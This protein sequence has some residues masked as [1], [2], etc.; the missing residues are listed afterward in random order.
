MI[1]GDIK[2]SQF[3]SIDGM[4]KLND[5]NGC[6]FPSWDE[7]KGEYCNREHVEEQEKTDIFR[8]GQLFNYL[9]RGKRPYDDPTTVTSPINSTH[10][11]DAYVKRA[12]IMCMR[13]HHSTARQ[14]ANFLHTGYS[15]FERSMNMTLERGNTAQRVTRMERGIKMLRGRKRVRSHRR[16][17]R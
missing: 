2:P 6:I 16:S 3:I 17:L 11:F 15:K 5:F 4:Y 10:P 9:L 12:M 8:L 13:Q 14:V 7:T 1:H